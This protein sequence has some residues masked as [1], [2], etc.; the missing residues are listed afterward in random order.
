MRS[1]KKFEEFIKSGVVKIQSPDKS[2][3]EFLIKEAEQDYSNLLEQIDKIGIEERNANNFVNS[4]MPKKFLNSKTPKK[5]S[6]WER[7]KN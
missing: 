5:Y 2:R 3:A 4:E 1:I 6:I 7:Q